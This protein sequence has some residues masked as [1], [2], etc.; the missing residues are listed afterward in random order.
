MKL[1]TL[2]VVNTIVAGVFGIVFVLIPWQVLSLY[3]IVPDPAIN[4]V[5][6][7]FGAA[8]L[9]FA[10]MSWRA[11]KADD[12]DARQAIILAFFMGDCIG[13]IVALRGQFAGVVNSLGWSTVLIYLLL[14]IGFGYFKFVKPSS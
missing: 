7:L 5:G 12:S 8:L 1:S 10:L 9:T 6:Q 4:Y 3:G 14:A 2:M 11:R 13:F